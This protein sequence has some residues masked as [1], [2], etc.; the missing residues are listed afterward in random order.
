M[1]SFRGLPV[2]LTSLASGE[3]AAFSRDLGIFLAINRGVGGSSKAEQAVHHTRMPK[4]V[5]V[6]TEQSVFKCSPE[7]T[8]QAEVVE[9]R[10]S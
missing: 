5:E 1:T 7:Q 8:Q 9:R 2:G 4:Y 6:N 10:A 3:M